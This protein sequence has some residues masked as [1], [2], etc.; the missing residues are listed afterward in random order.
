MDK[1]ALAAAWK[2]YKRAVGS[3]NVIKSAHE[4]AKIEDAWAAF[5]VAADRVYTK[6]EQGSKIS[7]N[8]K[9]WWGKKV[10]ERRTDRLLCYVWHARNA[11]L[12]A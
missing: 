11:E 1:K 3:A 12:V 5:L 7:D 10:H 4:F 2:E 8:S 9:S 6:L